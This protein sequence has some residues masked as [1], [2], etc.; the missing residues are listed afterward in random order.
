ML[1][2]MKTKISQHLSGVLNI[3]E[4]E[5]FNNLELPSDPTLGDLAFPCFAL[6]KIRKL[7]PVKIASEEA[8]KLK[9]NLPSGFKSVAATG[10]YLNFFFDQPVWT[11]GVL[12]EIQAQ[13]NNFGD[14]LKVGSGKTVVFDYSSPNLAKPMSI[15]HLR[16]SVIGQSLINIFKSLGFKTIGI[17]Y[18]GDWGVQFGKLAWAEINLSDLLLRADKF[19]SQILSAGFNETVW[20]KLISDAKNPNYESFDYLYALYVIFHACSEFDKELDQF[21]RDYFL[22]LE[23]RHRDEFKNDPLA[24]KIEETWQHFLKISIAEGNRVYELLGIKH[25]LIRGESFH[26][27]ELENVVKELNN[28]ALLKPSQGALIVDLENYSMPPCLIQKSDGATLY[29]TRDIAAAIYRHDELKA[30]R[31]IYVVGAEQTLHFKQF[32][33]VLELMGH[34]WIKDCTHVS[35]GL[36]RFKEGKM[37]TRRGNV[38]FLED[39]L[40]RSI[41]LVKK[42]ISEKNPSLRDAD[43][44]SKQVGTAA[45]IFND[46]MNDRQKNIDFDWDRLLD[47]NGDTGPYVQYSHVRCQS[48]LNK[49]A[50]P[51]PPSKAGCVLKEK[52]ELDLIRILSRFESHLMLAYEQLKPNWVAHYLLDLAKAFSA[53]YYEHRVLEGDIPLQEA[54]VLLVDSTR[55]VLKKGLSLLGIQ[56]PD[57]M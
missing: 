27:P 3:S 12:D 35:F 55:I 5:I 11:V 24:K 54:R 53:F 45:V 13:Q 33:K 25:D 39:V 7:A 19:R 20:V 43:K 36:Y 4:N 47:F 21:G 30:D 34:S 31:L 8:E 48:V 14:N 38:V 40:F 17:N 37:S 18:L 52:L 42:V 10:G 28:K 44:V 16:S 57:A 6:A 50:K 23:K 49:W 32:F 2:I 46:L 26:E 1:T 22:I 15:G 29:A 56:A 9:S 51:I 41:D